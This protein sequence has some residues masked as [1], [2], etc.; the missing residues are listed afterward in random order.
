MKDLEFEAILDNGTPVTVHCETEGFRILDMFAQ[1]DAGN[2]TPLSP[3][4]QVRIGKQAD[5]AVIAHEAEE[6]DA[7]YERYRRASRKWII[8]ASAKD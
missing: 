8:D 1:D 2:E 3:S 4:E 6:I 7:T 5:E